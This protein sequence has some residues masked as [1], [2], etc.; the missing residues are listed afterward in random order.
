[1]SSEH[2]REHSGTIANGSV[3]V[4]GD[5]T[6]SGTTTTVNSTTVAVADSMLKVAKDN[7]GNATDFGLYGQFN[8]EFQRLIPLY[9]D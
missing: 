2:D 3:T 9:K 5:L 7:T 6:V 1:M 4:A 8:D